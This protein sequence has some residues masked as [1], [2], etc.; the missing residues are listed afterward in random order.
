MPE[1]VQLYPL[2]SA[3]A[4]ALG[5]ACLLAG[6]TWL[7]SVAKRDVSVVDGVWSLLILGSAMVGSWLLNGAAGATHPAML[8]LAAWALRLAI[9]ITW[10]GWGEPEDHRYQIIR[11]RNQPNF[12]FK[13]LYL[14]FALQAVLAWIVSFPLLAM[15]TTAAQSGSGE[16]SAPWLVA[17]GLAL[18]AA[19]LVYEAVADW[20]LAAFKRD[21]GSRGKVMNRGLWRY[22]RHPNYFGEFCV[23]WGLFLVALGTGGA[24]A[25]WVVLSPLL[26]STLLMKVSGVPML[27][28]GISARR[29][30]YRD[31]VLG[32]NAFFPGPSRTVHSS[33]GQS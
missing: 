27:E 22:S 11:A 8:L 30:G 15:A 13:S 2:S 18:S 5:A 33:G 4:W 24:A 19:G 9:H 26:M 23:W 17:A 28:N 16:A 21:P 7:L 25:A 6:L 29:P 3:L 14:V 12:A 20:Q 32:T 10:R 1:S 31:Y